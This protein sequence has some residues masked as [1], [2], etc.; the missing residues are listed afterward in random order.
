MPSIKISGSFNKRRPKCVYFYHFYFR[1]LSVILWN[2]NKRKTSAPG[3]LPVNVSP[4][5]SQKSRTDLWRR[6]TSSYEALF[7]DFY[8]SSSQNGWFCQICPNFSPGSEFR[9]FIEKADGFPD[10]SS[11]RVEFHLGLERR[12]K[13]VQNIQT[14]KSL[15]N[16]NTSLCITFLCKEFG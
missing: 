15:Q 5:N 12:Q 16:R 14:F 8:Y 9:P 13:A 4:G 10:H 11:Q 7:P 6:K 1:T 2:S 3:N